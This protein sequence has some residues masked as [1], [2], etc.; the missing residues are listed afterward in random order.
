M[1]Q[2]GPS[3]S[4]V[5]VTF[6]SSSTLPAALAALRR[7]AP[8][9][10]ELLV[11]ENGGDPSVTATVQ[12]A[13]PSATAIVNERNTGFAAGVNQGVAQAHG[14]A[15]L[16]LNPD[17][18][19]EPGSVAA[20]LA[21]L[22]ALPDA[23]MVAPRLIDRDGQP[24]L[25]CYPFLSLGTVAWRHFQLIRLFPNAVLGRY[26]RATLDPARAEPVPVAW[27]QGAC[28]L[29]RSGLLDRLGGFDPDFFLYA[30]EVDLARRA[31]RA[32]W[33][34]YLV[35]TARVR[36]AEGISTGQV[37]PL[38][39][40][41]HYFSKVV[42]FA[43][44]RGQTQTL[45]LRALLLLDLTLRMGYRIVGVVRGRPPDARQRLT[46][47]VDI[48]AALLTLPT[49]RLVEHW[50]TMGQGIGVP[51]TSP[52]PGKA[53]PPG[54]LSTAVERGRHLP[55]RLLAGEGGWGG[56]GQREGTSGA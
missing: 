24:V 25:S 7:A 8:A 49:D 42:Y 56:E 36:H 41:S 11:I 10:A 31:A 9:D 19:V 40:A 53:P 13:W 5:I 43:K 48:A 35:P 14:A 1:D 47:Y 30:E 55:P 39:L 18:E 32:G 21:A 3:L 20:L 44:H 17:A 29:I 27:A 50:R 22:D 12:A 28:V 6:R 46:A 34:T 15:I 38:K 2:P 51:A 45:V 54:P 4:T 23:G 37:V 33:R 16:L 26:R 52:G